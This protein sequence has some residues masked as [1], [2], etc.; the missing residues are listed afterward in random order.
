MAKEADPATVGV[1]PAVELSWPL[2]PGGFPRAFAPGRIAQ[3]PRA[4]ALLWIAL[5][6][7]KPSGWNPTAKDFSSIAPQAFAELE[8]LRTGRGVST[9]DLERVP[10]L[11]RRYRRLEQLLTDN[12]GPQAA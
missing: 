1:V 9:D 10:F 7:A 8:A 2:E 5:D 4:V 12:G 11:A 3:V 6:Y